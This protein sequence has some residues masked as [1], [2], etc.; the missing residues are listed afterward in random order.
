MIRIG[1]S[2]SELYGD[3]PLYAPNG[4][5]SPEL[6][7]YVND[8]IAAGAVMDATDAVALDSA[9]NV[10]EPEAPER[11]RPPRRY[12]CGTIRR[13]RTALDNFDLG[14][15]EPTKYYDP[16]NKYLGPEISFNLQLKGEKQ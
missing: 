4:R 7:R 6:R 12:Y 14:I 13:K 3:K 16:T 1:P 8:A 5:P 9:A 2:F 11:L 15:P 10:I